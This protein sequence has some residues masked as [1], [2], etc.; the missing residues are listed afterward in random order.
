M[1]YASSELYATPGAVAA[2]VN[3]LPRIG[4][5]QGVYPAANAAPKTSDVI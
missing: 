2:K 1:A 4:P 5:T 3:A